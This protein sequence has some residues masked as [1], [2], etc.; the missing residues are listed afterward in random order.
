MKKRNPF[1]YE[2]G[3]DNAAATRAKE[4]AAD[5]IRGGAASS[6]SA[7]VATIHGLLLD[8]F[9]FDERTIRGG[10][11][12]C[13]AERAFKDKVT[14]GKCTNDYTGYNRQSVAFWW[15]K[16][17]LRLADARCPICGGYLR[18]TSL[19]LYARFERL[20]DDKVPEPVRYRDGT[21]NLTRRD[22]P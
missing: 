3:H 2:G 4:I 10:Y 5:L 12:R 17:T 9:D 20:P 22:R 19:A 15:P 6:F 11:P 8:E 21:A 7:E 1:A 18:Q 16:G 13:L 14:I